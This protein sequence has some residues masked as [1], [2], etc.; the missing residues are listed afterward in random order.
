M[1][2][3]N[4][5]VIGLGIGEQH[6]IGYIQSKYVDKIYVFDFDNEKQDH[7]NNK[8]KNESIIFCKDQYEIL[9]NNEVNAVSIASYDQFHFDQIMIAIKNNFYKS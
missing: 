7:I 8:Y 4:V 1:Q 9:K 6:L 3:I 5:R 2:K